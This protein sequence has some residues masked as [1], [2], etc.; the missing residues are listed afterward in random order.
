MD[1][2]QRS[3]TVSKTAQTV[4]KE[5]PQIFWGGGGTICPE[6]IAEIIRFQFLRCTSY[7]TAS[8]INCPRGTRRQTFFRGFFVALICFEKQ[9]LGLFRGFSVAFSWPSCW[10]NFTRARPR[11]VFWQLIVQKVKCCNVTVLGY[12]R[13][14]LSQVVG[15]VYMQ[16]FSTHQHA[17]GIRGH[18]EVLPEDKEKAR[19]IGQHMRAS[20]KAWNPQKITILFE[21]ITF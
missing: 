2:K 8:K 13:V 3:S 10:A 12:M 15:G 4:S 9:C 5:L 19:S 17:G 14:G 21:I 20:L 16:C 18:L 11:K 6:T 1:C 7:V